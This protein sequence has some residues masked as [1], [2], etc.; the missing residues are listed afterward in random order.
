MAQLLGRHGVFLT[1]QKTTRSETSVRVIL[2]RYVPKSPWMDTWGPAGRVAFT[3]H[4]P[5]S[6]H[7]RGDIRRPISEAVVRRSPA[8]HREV[9]VGGA[10]D[11]VDERVGDLSW[12]VGTR[13][14]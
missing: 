1:C 2:K 12:G 13:H 6:H 14:C 4:A 11:E 9:D 7:T 10:E 5:T 3:G 8:G